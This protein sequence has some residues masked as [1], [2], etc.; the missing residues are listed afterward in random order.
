MKSLKKATRRI[1]AAS[2]A[3][4]SAFA[5]AACSA[6]QTSQTATQVGAVDG[7]SAGNASVGVSVDDVT[8]LVDDATNATSLKFVASNQDPSG[9]SYTLK[10]VTV[11]GKNVTVKGSEPIAQGCSLLADAAA[12]LKETPKGTSQ[13]ICTTYAE[14][15]VANGGWAYGTQ[16]PV[17]FTFDGL[18]PIT[19]NA[20]VSAPTVPAGSETR[21]YQGNA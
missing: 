4:L 12:H 17:A 2:I 15:T 5:L 13:N 10:S 16:V 18:S 19:V 3:A 1:G 6:S 9:A 7:A 21:D 20:T 8:V 14:T 11:D